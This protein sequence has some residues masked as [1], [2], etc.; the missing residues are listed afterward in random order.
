MFQTGVREHKSV[1]PV[2]TGHAPSDSEGSAARGTRGEEC[3][4]DSAARGKVARGA[5]GQG[6]EGRRPQDAD[7]LVTGYTEPQA[8]VCPG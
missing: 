5:A 3:N 6:G 4:K 8:K 2:G 7:L 1:T